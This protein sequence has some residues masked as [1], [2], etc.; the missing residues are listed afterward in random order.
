MNEKGIQLTTLY[1]ILEISHRATQED[2]KSA[3][4]RLAKLY[5]PDTNPHAS[6]E[7]I[8]HFQ[9][10]QGAYKILYDPEQRCLYDEKEIKKRLK[11]Q[12]KNFDPLFNPLGDLFAHMNR[13]F[14]EAPSAQ[15]KETEPPVLSYSLKITFIEACLGTQKTITLNEGKMDITI[16]P[17]V[18]HKSTLEFSLKENSHGKIIIMLYVDSHPHMRRVDQDIHLTLPITFHES[19]AGE[20]I[21]IPTLQGPCRIKI[22]PYV[23]S[24]TE[25]ILKEKGIPGKIPG[26]FY[27]K[28]LITPPTKHSNSLED[29]LRNWEK[30]NPYK[31]RAF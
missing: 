14:S 24:G 16:P 7:R 12:S 29:I 15:Q 20:S 18:T 27:V 1:A 8:A 10:I 17:G 2:I 31:P 25:L 6:P 23:S 11:N 19:I 9:K 30:S 22:P 13:K 3:Y 28:I 4:R 5:H 21:E 26:N